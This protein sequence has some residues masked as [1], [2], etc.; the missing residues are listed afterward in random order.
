MM[1]Q[2]LAHF[3]LAGVELSSNFQLAQLVLEARSKYP[4]R[5]TLSSE[6]IG[7]EQTGVFCETAAIHLDHS[8]HL[9]ELLLK[10]L[11]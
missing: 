4:V 11:K 9:A 1:M 10:P 6:A 7:Q 3:E 8:G 2:L 5:V